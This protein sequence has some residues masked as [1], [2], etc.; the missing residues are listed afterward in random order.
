MFALSLW[1]AHLIKHTQPQSHSFYLQRFCTYTHSLSLSP[2]CFTPNTLINP[3][4]L[5]IF[6]FNCTYNLSLYLSHWLP[7]SNYL[8]PFLSTMSPPLSFTYQ[9]TLLLSLLLFSHQTLLTCSITLSLS[10]SLS[11]SHCLM[12]YSNSEFGTIPTHTHTSTYSSIVLSL[13]PFH[14]SF[15]SHFLLQLSLSKR[16]EPVSL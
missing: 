1:F 13:P 5:A 15:L 10:L 16:L 3:T 9:R 11:L 14:P 4:H 8:L 7:S 12:F 6:S 2:S